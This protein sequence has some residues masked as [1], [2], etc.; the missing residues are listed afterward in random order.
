ML[1]LIRDR[2][3]QMGHMGLGNQIFVD[4]ACYHECN[5]RVRAIDYNDVSLLKL[6]VLSA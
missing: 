5:N 6:E 2:Q 1:L 3:W 4:V